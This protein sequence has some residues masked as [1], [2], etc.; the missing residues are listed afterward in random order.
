MSREPVLVALA[1]PV[2][3]AAGG[4]CE[5]LAS[6]HTTTGVLLAL[7][8]LLTAVGAAVARSRVSPVK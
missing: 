7:A 5:Q 2:L 8:S 4:A 6:D 3:L 1:G